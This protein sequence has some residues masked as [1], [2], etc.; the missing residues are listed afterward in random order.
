MKT[1]IKLSIFTKLPKNRTQRSQKL[2]M[3][4]NN[5][6]TQKIQNLTIMDLL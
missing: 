2:Y 1:K 4:L 5:Q 6:K 3:T